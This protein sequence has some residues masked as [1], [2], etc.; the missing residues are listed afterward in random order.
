M[1]STSEPSCACTA[2]LSLRERKC[3]QTKLGL[4]WAAVH[5]LKDKPLA[6]VTVK[7]LCEEVQ[8]SEATFFNYFRKKDDLLRYFIQIWT[9]QM[10]WHARKGGRRGLELI[11]AVFERTGQEL[12]KNPRP[13]LEIIGH[14]ALQPPN[15]CPLA[16]GSLDRQADDLGPT[17]AALGLPE[18]TRAERLLAF[19]QLEGTED[20]PVVGLDELFHDGLLEAARDQE[21]PSEAAIIQGVDSLLVTFFGIPLCFGQTMPERIPAAY[22]QQLQ[23]IFAG[24]QHLPAK[25]TALSA[26]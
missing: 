5:R 10:T 9:I 15:Q 24:L 4:L 21:L 17:C 6:E 22:E 25:S 11:R 7:E 8:V 23:L 16:Q 1:S 14:M 26:E 3:A 19:P 12:A 20:I 18:P 13:I 2:K